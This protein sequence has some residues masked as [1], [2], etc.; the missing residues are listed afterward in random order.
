MKKHRKLIR[1]TLSG[2]AHGTVVTTPMAAAMIHILGL[3]L[4][5]KGMAISQSEYRALQKFYG[6]EEEKPTEKPEP[7]EPPTP[8]AANAPYLDRLNYDAALRAH[9]EKLRV[10]NAWSDPKDLM[11][12]GANRNMMRHAEAD[13]LRVMVWIA[14]FLS[15]GEDPVKT[16]VQLAIEAGWDVDPDEVTWLYEGENAEEAVAE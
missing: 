14:K 5:H 9:K 3:G 11:Q 15:P 13:G 7:P 4:T 8:P 2:N 1:P 6:Y 12:A 16:L 10:H